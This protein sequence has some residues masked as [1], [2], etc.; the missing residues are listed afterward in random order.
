M[1]DFNPEEGR[2]LLCRL[3]DAIRQ[4][5][6]EVRARDGEGDFAQITGE[7]R[8]DI[9]YGLDRV[10][11]EAIALWFDEFWP[12]HQPVELVFEG[13]DEPWI[14]PRG[15]PVEQTLWKCIL[16]P[17][18]GTRVLMYDKRSAW[19]LAAL[20]PQRGQATSLSDI[21]VA[22]MTEIPTAKQGLADQISARRGA[23]PEGIKA[24]RI[25]LAT[26]LRRAL[27]PLPSQAENFEH[28][29]ASFSRFFP[30]AK[31]LLAQVEERLWQALSGEN[32]AMPVVFDD[33][34]LST[35]GQIY[36]L[37][38]GHD[39]MLG[40]LRPLALRRLGSAYSL[41]C[42]PYDICVALILQEA[43]GVL[44]SPDGSPLDAPLDI[45]SP[46]AWVGF[47]NPRLAEQVRPHLHR[48][49]RELL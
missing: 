8:A 21:E 37:L 33:Q 30:E 3:S 47:A 10:A 26:G 49:M 46:I 19:V 36:E 39:R 16:D 2:R 28:G 7:T 40:D 24:E 5:I 44:E 14:F 23:G 25:E 38:M 22:V 12:A 48:I 13:A 15:T 1:N 29:F 9:I 34:Y 42:H 43:G 35:G 6:I 27:R 45:S 11:E 31:G 18:D 41:V 4:R 20:A 17:V 32:G